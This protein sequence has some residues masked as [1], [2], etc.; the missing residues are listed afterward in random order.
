MSDWRSHTRAYRDDSK[1]GIAISFGLAVPAVVI[2]VGFSLDYAAGI[3][4]DRKLQDVADQAAIAAAREL[5]VGRPKQT[6]VQAVAQSF[7]AAA[8][9]PNGE[10]PVSVATSI[11]DNTSSVTVELR[12]ER[13]FKF[14][15]LLLRDPAGAFASAT[16]RFVGS[17]KMCVV[18]LGTANQDG[19]V[20]NKQSGISA[21]GCGVYSNSSH[22]SRRLPWL[23]M[24]S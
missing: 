10:A 15:G 24:H 1:A 2:A 12:Q 9:G 7:V 14:S 23:T 22:P 4:Q 17:T 21:G 18:A 6:Q 8:L 11:E 13:V 20:M 5:A 3:Y 19:L 16:A